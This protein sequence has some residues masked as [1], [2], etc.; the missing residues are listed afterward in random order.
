M[1][2]DDGG[3]YPERMKGTGLDWWR[4]RRPGWVAR[5][6]LV[7]TMPLAGCSNGLNA[8]GSL[9]S[10][11]VIDRYTIGGP[12]DCATIR[13]ATCDEYLRIA[14]D[15]ATGKRGVAPASIIAHR[16]YYESISPGSTLGGP[17]VAV[18]VFDLANGS[19]VAVGA[20]CGVGPCQVVPR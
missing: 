9:V 20:Y 11:T 16:F 6:A 3:R 18:V 2:C 14:T 8:D 7:L 4:W 12:L 5:L 15:T 1:L 10:G 17:P 13:D 19:R